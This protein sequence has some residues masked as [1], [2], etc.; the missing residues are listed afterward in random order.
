MKKIMISAGEISGDIFAARLV[1]ELRQLDPSLSFIGMGGPR[2][3][4]A[5]VEISDDVTAIST[6]GF[7]EPVRYIPRIFNVYR[8]QCQ[9][10]KH[11]RP[12]LYVPVDLQGFHMRILKKAKKLDIPAIY[13]I[14]PQEWHWGSDKGG[15]E[16]IALTEKTLAIFQAEADFYNRLGGSASFVG[17][18]I[19]EIARATTSRKAFCEEYGLKDG[20]ELLAVFPGSRRQEIRDTGPLLFESARRLISNHQNLQPVV[21]VVS[22]KY[23]TQIRKLVAE[24]GLADAMFIRGDQHNLI[25]H[26]HLS[27]AASGSVAL[28]HAVMGT[29]CIVAYRFSRLTE[30]LVGF[31]LNRISAKVAFMS[32]PNILLGRKV[33]PEF[34]RDQATADNLVVAADRLL[35]NPDY[36]QGVK[37]GMLG[38]HRHMGSG[39]ATKRAAEEIIKYLNDGGS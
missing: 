37:Q 13:Y 11:A 34:P 5:G 31:I 17:H 30:L 39:G 24:A 25:A 14:A 1:E 9:L 12:D 21:S 35:D 36:Y 28:E 27:L 33:L 23:D 20:R 7:L 16:V 15:R 26:S 8:R 10:M 19:L 2:M 29:P 38:V 3:R 18:P 22:E 4:E 6:I 32:M